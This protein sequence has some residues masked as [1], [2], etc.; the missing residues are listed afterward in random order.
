VKELKGFAR[1]PLKAGEEKT[2]TFTFKTDLLSFYKN[3]KRILEGGE[4]DLFIGSSSRDIH[5][6]FL[7]TVKDGVRILDFNS[8]ND[9]SQVM[10][11]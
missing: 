10:I 7:L 5:H 1:V 9:R 3:G 8:W 6:S 4:F 2:V 11:T